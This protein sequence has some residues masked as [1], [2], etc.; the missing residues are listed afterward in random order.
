MSDPVI[1]V[2]DSWS[3]LK[4]Y[5]AA[6]IALGR[7]GASLPTREVLGFRLDHA[8]AR[9]AVLLELD[10]EALG[11][12]LGALGVETLRLRSLCRDK[13][14]YLKRPDFGRRLSESSRAELGEAAPLGGCDLAL[15]VA[16][17]LSSV[18]VE[19]QALPLL[20]AFLPFCADLSLGPL[21]LAKYGRVALSDE[22][23]SILAAKIVII[24]IGER[25]GLSSPD[26]LGAY[27]TFGPSIG[28]TDERRNCVSN[29]RPEGLEPARAARKLD[30]LVRESLKRGISGV[31]LKDEQS[32]EV[33]GD[34]VER[35]GGSEDS[36]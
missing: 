35:L 24:L 7:A 16:D 23:G 20:S 8:R 6:R 25:P 27:L 31:G 36:A 14:E 9:D 21:C 19:R 26:S 32:A 18:A 3:S 5:T 1:R 28:T 10:L 29:I 30:Y 22:V 2:E 13:A 4:R 33:L 11:D 15:V 34:P 12:E 17:G